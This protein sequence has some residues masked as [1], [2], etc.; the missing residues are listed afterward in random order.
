MRSSFVGVLALVLMA[1]FFPTSGAE[2]PG[3]AT[4]DEFKAWLVANALVEAHLLERATVTEYAAEPSQEG[5]SV[6]LDYASGLLLPAPAALP[7]LPLRE[8]GCLGMRNTLGFKVE[9]EQVAPCP[10][11]I[12]GTPVWAD[13]LACAGQG[14]CFQISQN[15]DFFNFGFV[16]VFCP[17]PG[18]TAIL[19]QHNQVVKS[20]GCQVLA[21]GSN[22]LTWTQWIGVCGG[23][24]VGAWKCAAILK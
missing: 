9:P 10:L 18:A 20:P 3:P 19:I 1:S 15:L 4:L 24:G 16:A 11:Q 13:A 2:R 12:H 22:P 6:V 7:A 5:V 17:Q 14:T 8:A 21:F 23:F